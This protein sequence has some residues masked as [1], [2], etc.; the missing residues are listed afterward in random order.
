MILGGPPIRTGLLQNIV[1]GSGDSSKYDLLG[2][3][4]GDGGDYVMGRMLGARRKLSKKAAAKA[5][6]A[7]G[8]P[9]PPLPWRDRDRLR[10]GGRK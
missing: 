6:K 4:F 1:L 5:L 8:G 3:S 9:D 7:G 2:G 10:G